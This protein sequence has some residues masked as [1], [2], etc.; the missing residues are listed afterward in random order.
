MITKWLRESFVASFLLLAVR[1]Y[2]GWDW[3]HHG[4][5][6]ISGGT[7]DATGFIKNAVAKPVL[8]SATKETLYPTFVSFLNNFAL[9]NANLFKVLIPWGEFLVGLGLILGTLTGAAAFFGCLMNFM[10]MFAGTVSSNPWLILLGFI[11]ILGSRN[12]GRWGGDY[13][14]LPYLRK[15]FKLDRFGQSQ[16]RT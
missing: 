2:L 13:Y 1:L 6:K 9:P 14:I 5:Q 12:S 10:F 16:Q 8:D 3:M 11:I 15:L 7:F 4:W